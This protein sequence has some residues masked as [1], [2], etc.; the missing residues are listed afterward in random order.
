MPPLL[1]DLQRFLDAQSS[2]Y[3][4]VVAEL[5]ALEKRTHWMW[6]IFPQIHGL[7]ASSMAQRY[8]ISGL[9]EAVAYLAH[10]IL[11][12][13]LRECTARLSDHIFAVD[14]RNLEDILG[15]PD[16]LKFHSSITLFL[17][18]AHFV[19]DES[20]AAIFTIAL[21][22]FFGGVLDQPTLARLTP[23]PHGAA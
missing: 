4:E 8:A 7:G 6:F 5:T 21:E 18:A 13:R 20:S 2:V 3:P 19:A 1:F 23:T 22:K 17:Q 11:G 9:P 15:Y 10:P 16:N 14:H 12:A